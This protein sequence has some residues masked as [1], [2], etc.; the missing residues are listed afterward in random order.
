MFTWKKR[1]IK[2]WRFKSAFECKRA[3]MWRTYKLEIRLNFKFGFWSI[4]I[5]CISNF[6]LFEHVC[7]RFFENFPFYL[8]HSP[9]D[10]YIYI[11]KF[12][13]KTNQKRK[14]VTAMVVVTL[15][16]FISLAF[17][18]YRVRTFQPPITPNVILFINRPGRQYYIAGCSFP[19][20]GQSWRHAWFTARCNFRAIISTRVSKWWRRRRSIISLSVACKLFPPP[21]SWPCIAKL[22]WFPR[23]RTRTISIQLK[24]VRLAKIWIQDKFRANEE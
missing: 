24:K 4:S 17:P 12:L 14:Q 18:L 11:T 6:S 21:N 20:K 16:S 8:L 19:A 23:G 13:E 5:R 2:S 10:H 9:I 1:E 7:R 22:F 3:N 15:Y